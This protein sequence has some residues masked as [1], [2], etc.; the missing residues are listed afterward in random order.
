MELYL[1]L[2]GR[3]AIAA[4]VERL[5]RR[6]RL[7]SGFGGGNRPL[8]ASYAEDLTEFLVF[9]T[10]GAPIY[11]GRPVS[12]LLRPL[13]PSPEAFEI[14]VDHVVTVLI[15]RERRPAE[16]AQLRR[17]LEHVRPMV[18]CQREEAPVDAGKSFQ[19]LTVVA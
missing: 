15:G 6:L 18:L 5:D 12:M 16:E 17:L 13:C 11:E 1:S 2:G 9:V 4:A 10:G 8:Q 7:D 3:P 19:R 14:L